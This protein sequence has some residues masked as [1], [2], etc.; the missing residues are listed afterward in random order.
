[1]F[2]PSSLKGPISCFLGLRHGWFN[3][4][5]R[6]PSRDCQHGLKWAESGPSRARNRSSRNRSQPD[7]LSQGDPLCAD[8]SHDPHSGMVVNEPT[9]RPSSPLDFGQRLLG[10]SVTPLKVLPAGGWIY[11]LKPRTTAA[12]SEVGLDEDLT[13]A[14]TADALL[15]Q[16]SLL[17]QAP[18]LL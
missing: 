14:F 12:T 13:S 16:A 7:L 11:L 2:A 18:A 15:A 1:M 5:I 8:A 6:A 3:V 4:V 9:F 17:S 10:T